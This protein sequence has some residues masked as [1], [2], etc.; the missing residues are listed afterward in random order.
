MKIAVDHARAD[1]AR[2]EPETVEIQD[3]LTRVTGDT[4]WRIK[5]PACSSIIGFKMEPPT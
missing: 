5:C 2:S 3:V 1:L 4:G